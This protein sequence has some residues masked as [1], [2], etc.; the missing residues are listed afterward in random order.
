MVLTTERLQLTRLAESDWPFFLTLRQDQAIMKYMSGVAPQAAIRAK[1]DSRLLPWAPGSFE[2]LDFI[3][4]ARGEVTPLGEIGFC[5]LRDSPGEAEVGYSLV[6]S[7]QGR[8]IASEA[9]MALCRFAFSTGVITSLKAV[10]VA[11][12]HP[13]ARVVEKLGFRWCETVEQGYFSQ[14][15]YYDDRIYRLTPANLARAPG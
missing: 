8:G 9:L 2:A 4:R 14:G 11:E 15:S 10:V 13:S 5:Q 1:F 12:N 6:A 7:A 3:I